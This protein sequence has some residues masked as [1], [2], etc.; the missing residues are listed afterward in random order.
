VPDFSRLSA[1]QRR[2]V[3]AGDGPLLVMAGPGSGKTTTMAARVAHLVEE[4]RVGAASVLAVT[5]TRAAAHALRARLATMLGERARQ[6]DVTTFHGLGLR[7]V[8]HWSR[9][10]GYPPG[11]LRVCRD[12]AAR[13]LLSEAA[14][15]AGIDLER[16]PPQLERLLERHRLT[17]DADGG[18]GNGHSRALAALAAAYERL[19]LERRLVDYP[20]MLVLP[21]R[22]FLSH[23]RALRVC[24]DAYRAIL[25]D[26]FQDVCGAQY[27]LLRL[28]AERHRNLAVVGDPCQSVYGWRGAEPALFERFLRDFPEAQACSLDQNFRSTG[29][30]VGLANALG[31]GL[32]FPRRLWTDN[33][34]GYRAV[35]HEAADEAAEAAYVAAE[36]RRLLETGAIR[37]AGEVAV[38]YRT[39]GQARAL[40]RALQDGGLPYRLEPHPELVEGESG[41]PAA[42]GADV[43]ELLDQTPRVALTTIHGAKGGEWRVVFVV[44][45]EEG[46]LPHSATTEGP[47]AQTTALADELRVAYV[48]VT[49]PR[50]RLYL[51]YCRRRRRGEWSAPV[52]P[53]RFLRRLPGELVAAADAPAA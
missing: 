31:A 15:A 49:R 39:N 1:E 2:V 14:A 4:R 6:V 13:A 53:S 30:I 38:L 28:L 18:G 46:L 37:H 50:E 16:A 44:G 36:I 12:G 45:L 43:L 23:P 3:L 20:A 51:T 26:E 19:L 27:A 7:L 5:F 52:D 11:M 8:R 17:A 35:V 29:C 47:A 24:Q 33:P 9:Q 40:R 48:A 34:H 25:A 22:L 21:V 32:G 41:G 10:I 42:G